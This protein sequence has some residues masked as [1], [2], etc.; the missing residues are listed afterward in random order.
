MGMRNDAIHFF[1]PVS[2]STV[3]ARNAPGARA[4][5]RVPHASQVAERKEGH[6]GAPQ[7]GAPHARAGLAHK[8]ER[9]KVSAG[10]DKIRKRGV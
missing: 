4:H 5:E 1:M 6:R 8:E 3:A 7:E 2:A 9:Q 10:L